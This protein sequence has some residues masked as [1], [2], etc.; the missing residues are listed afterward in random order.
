MIDFP[1]MVPFRQ[2][3]AVLAALAIGE[4]AQDLPVA[5]VEVFVEFGAFRTWEHTV[6][7]HFREG[8]LQV[9]VIGDPGLVEIDLGEHEIARKDQTL[10]GVKPALAD[11]EAKPSL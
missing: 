10:C 1:V 9:D 6:G 4:Q 3:P 8:V 2:S 7:K 5:P 11:S